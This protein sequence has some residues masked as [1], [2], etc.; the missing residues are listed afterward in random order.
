MG[1]SQADSRMLLLLQPEPRQVGRSPA[2]GGGGVDMRRIDG[3]LVGVF[4]VAQEETARLE[5]GRWALQS[6]YKLDASS[7]PPFQ[8]TSSLC[9]R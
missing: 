5:A 7:N 8:L 3:D 1:W 9:V 2:L 4:A 6:Q